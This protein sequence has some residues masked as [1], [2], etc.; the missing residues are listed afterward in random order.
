MPL[1]HHSA[2]LLK[3]ADL[4]TP[5]TLRAA[6][7]L[8][9][10]DH[11][12]EGPLTATQLAERTGCLVRPL[13]RALA[14]LAALGV[15]QDRGEDTY[16]LAELGRPLLTDPSATTPGVRDALDCEG[17][18]G[19]A[20]LSITALV[21]T[22]RT[23][24][25]AYEGAH[26]RTVWED[27]DSGDAPRRGLELFATAA[28]SFDAAL[29]VDGYDWSGVTSVTDVGGNSGALLCS[30]LRRHPHLRGTVVDLPRFADLARRRLAEEGLADRA[31]AV[32]GSFFDP[33]PTGSDVYLLSGI[34][35]DW[36]DEQ[37]VR[38]LRRCAAAAGERGRVLLAEIHMSAPEALGEVERTRFELWLEA[39]M[40]DP[41][42]TP[43]DLERLA[44]E[45][46]LHPTWRAP[47]APTRSLIEFRV[48]A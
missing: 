31:D 20:E 44:K 4:V 34:L 40:G 30:L 17:I 46:G 48:A 47:A 21:H 2:T 45:A 29:V 8:R 10:A 1:D 24:A 19:R 41:D 6:A 22:L 42:R 27:V 38:I 23:G 36:N 18:I 7:T 14:H 13:R 9:L 37:A 25:S 28:A 35:A 5:M 3:L 33:L 15:L 43:D 12:A 26:G 16:A 32:G 39:G 11:L